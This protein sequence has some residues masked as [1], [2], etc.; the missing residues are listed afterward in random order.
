M[1]TTLYFLKDDALSGE[2]GFAAK[3]YG[4]KPD[5]K[6]TPNEYAALTRKI[7]LK[8]DFGWKEVQNLQKVFS[9]ADIWDDFPAE[10]LKFV[11][12]E[13]KGGDEE[14]R[15]DLL[16]LRND[17]GLYPC[18]LKLGG[19]SLDTHGQL[20]RYIS[21]L[22]YQKIDRSW[23]INQRIEYLKRKGVQDEREHR[24]ERTQFEEFFATN[25]IEDKHVHLLR[26]SGII[27]D[28]A[29][30]PQMLKAVRHLNEH[31]GFSI[32][33]LRL[34]TYVAP[35]WVAGSPR[36]IARVDLIEVQ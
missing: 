36:Y 30:K 29:F 7:G 15:I 5:G 20:I 13:T 18:E 10:G 8:D 32:R 21:D 4:I 14:Q 33:L 31:C 19:Q 12:A 34:D 23:I 26:N 35:N 9:G 1:A 11:T 2:T 16:Y 24:I 25:G 28:E 22:H 3:F 27:V 6:A 17:G